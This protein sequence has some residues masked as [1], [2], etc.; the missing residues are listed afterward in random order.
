MTPPDSSARKPS[1]LAQLVGWLF[2]RRSPTDNA[3]VRGG[4]RLADCLTQAT[5]I[6]RRFNGVGCPVLPEGP[7]VPEIVQYLRDKAG[8]EKLQPYGR[9]MDARE[10]AA[11]ALECAAERIKAASPP[12][13]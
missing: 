2:S 9:D 3:V 10:W 1:W 7:T 4:K 8:W 5:A 6:R 12:N 11:N 13:K